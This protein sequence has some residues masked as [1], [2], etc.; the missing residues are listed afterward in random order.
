MTR[1]EP[2]NQ[3]GTAR[4][5]SNQPSSRTDATQVS[6]RDWYLLLIFI[7]LALIIIIRLIYLQVIVAPEYREQSAAQRTSEITVSARRGTIYDRNGNP[8]ATSVDATTIYANP[9]E[10]EDPEA[11][12]TLLAE[13]VGGEYETYYSLLTQ[14]N[15]FVYILRKGDIAI[16]DALKAKE[17]ELQGE[18]DA[19]AQEISPTTQPESSDLFGIHYLDDSRRVYPYGQIG[20]QVI[21]YVG[22]D[23]KAFRLTDV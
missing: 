16:A 9:N 5:R 15:T 10:V 6:N 7:G 22:L 23:D 21:G 11:T 18:L 2:H 3:A 19:K 8:L 4:K 13:I 17:A 12:A 1:Q 20:G 14:N